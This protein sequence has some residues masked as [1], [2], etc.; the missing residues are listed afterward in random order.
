MYNVSVKRNME[1]DL[2]EAGNLVAQ[3]LQEDFEFICK[4]IHELK[5]KMG[6]LRDF[7][8]E[9]FKRSAEVHDA[10]KV[11]LGYYMTKRNYDEFM[12]LQRVY[13]NVE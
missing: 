9:D 10:M 3:V 4:E 11:L 12:E 6:S 13:G 2:E 8:V 7:E 1:I 5:R